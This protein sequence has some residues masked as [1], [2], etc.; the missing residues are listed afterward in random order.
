MLRSEFRDTRKE[1]CNS[2]RTRRDGRRANK[3]H[4]RARTR[5]L[6][7]NCCKLRYMKILGGLRAVPEKPNLTTVLTRT[8]FMTGN[9]IAHF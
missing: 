3:G 6:R 8:P 2:R 7:M 4:R 1:L 9:G 5:L